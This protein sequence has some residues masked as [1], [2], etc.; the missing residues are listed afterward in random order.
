[1]GVPGSIQSPWESAAGGIGRNEED[2]KLAAIGESI[3]RY[4][5]TLIQVPLKS[6]NSVDSL[7]TKGKTQNSHLKT[8]IRIAAY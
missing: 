5:A 4:C 2:A 1:M 8:F 3:E 6:K 7:K